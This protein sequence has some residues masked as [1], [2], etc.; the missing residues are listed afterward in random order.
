MIWGEAHMIIIEIT[1]TKN[2]MH[3]NYPETIPPSC[4]LRFK[5]KV[6]TNSKNWLMGTSLEVQKLGMPHLFCRRHRFNPLTGEETKTLHAMWHPPP[7]NKKSWLILNKVGAGGGGGVGK[8][9]FHVRE[10][11]HALR[12][13]LL[14]TVG[15]E[16]MYTPGKLLTV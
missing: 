4:L 10:M 15:F 5:L 1:C 12:K 7:Q 2:V 16:F 13:C 11:V 14:F 6:Y 3:L 8:H 9:C